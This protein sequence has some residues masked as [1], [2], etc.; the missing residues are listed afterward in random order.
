MAFLRRHA[1][2]GFVLPDDV[3]RFEVEAVDHPAV[4]VVRLDASAGVSTDLQ[5]LA[6]VLADRRCEKDLL[7]PDYR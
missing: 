6:F 4:H 2:V 3:A 5:L 7:A 1:A